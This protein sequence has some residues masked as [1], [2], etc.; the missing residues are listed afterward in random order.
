[1]ELKGKIMNVLGD[2][3]TEGI[4]VSSKDKIY[5]NLLKDRLGLAEVRNYGDAGK[6][7]AAQQQDDGSWSD[8]RNFYD[9]AKKMDPNA[10]IVVVFGGTNDF[11]HG[12]A[13]LGS[14]GDRNTHSF[15]GACHVLMRYLTETY[16]DA[17]IVF[18]TPLHRCQEL[19]KY[20][21]GE[22]TV[23]S[24]PLF[25][26]VQA[27][28]RTAEY[29]AIPV[30]DLYSMSGIQPNIPVIRE[31]YCPD[32]LHPNDAGHARIADRLEWFLRSY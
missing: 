11:G 29:Y 26:Y 23:E 13:P 22:K 25:D 7:F 24:A 5:C 12:N 19:G 17:V 1:M 14:F 8:H 32:R 18:M 28:R 31:K 15:Y 20:G 6:R 27:I 2:S 30:L 4:G 10:D 9:L 16:P 3:I 21:G